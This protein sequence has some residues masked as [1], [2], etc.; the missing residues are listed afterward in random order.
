[1]TVSIYLSTYLS[2]VAYIIPT[3]SMLE[4]AFQWLRLLIVRSKE[5]S[6]DYRRFFWD[7]RNVWL[8]TVIPWILVVSL[9]CKEYSRCRQVG[10]YVTEG[11]VDVDSMVCRR[12][13]E[14]HGNW[15]LLLA[16]VLNH[17][18][19]VVPHLFQSRYFNIQTGWRNKHRNFTLQCQHKKV[20]TLNKTYRKIIIT[21]YSQQFYAV[22]LNILSKSVKFIIPIKH[23]WQH[24]WPESKITNC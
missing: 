16:V 1:M 6:G 15:L 24:S 14:L 5:R 17:Y 11:V 23:F 22:Q 9:A 3:Y 2:K 19:D 12:V 13:V 7:H 8:L 20:T 4:T 21:T 10:Q 18:P